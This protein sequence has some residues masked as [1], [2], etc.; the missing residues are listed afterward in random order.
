MTTAQLFIL[1][2]AEVGEADADLRRQAPQGPPFRLAQYLN[3]VA[4]TPF[5]RFPD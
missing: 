5:R 1:D 3:P 4:E 2:S